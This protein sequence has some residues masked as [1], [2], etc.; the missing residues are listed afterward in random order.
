[1]TPWISLTDVDFHPRMVALPGTSLV[2]IGT[3]ACGACRVFRALARGL[4]EG[5]VDRIVEV[6]AA[7]APG[8]L[9]ELEVFHLPGLFLWKDGE[10]WARVQS[11]ARP[12]ALADAIRAAANGPCMP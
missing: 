1:M 7:R 9:D 11:V 8:L 6:D 4:P 3:E 12:A 5:L 10:D 2:V